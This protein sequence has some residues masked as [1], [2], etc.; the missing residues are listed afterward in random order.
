MTP[1]PLAALGRA[2][3]LSLYAISAL[4]WLTGAVWLWLRAYGRV[5]GPYGPDPSPALPAVRAAH[6]AAAMA[7]LVAVGALLPDHVRYGWRDKRRRASG[8]PLLAACAVLAA[9]GWGLYY[10]S[11]DAAR[12]DASRVHVVVGIALPA[13]IAVHVLL[14]RRRRF[15]I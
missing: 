6:G 10:L 15:R 2:R 3:R 13:L 9:T 5:S 7:F 1:R 4:A 8:A 14:K 11:G 12:A